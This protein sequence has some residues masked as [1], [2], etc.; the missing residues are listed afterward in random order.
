[1]LCPYACRQK[2]P[3][4][5][6]IPPLVQIKIELRFSSVEMIHWKEVTDIMVERIAEKRYHLRPVAHCAKGCRR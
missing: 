5:L 2:P 1:M 3:C 6:S 4:T